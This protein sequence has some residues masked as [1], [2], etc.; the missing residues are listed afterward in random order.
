MNFHG[1]I[2]KSN[3]CLSGHCKCISIYRLKKRAAWHWFHCLIFNRLCLFSSRQLSSSHFQQCT[4]SSLGAASIS[5]CWTHKS[6][7]ISQSPS[8]LWIR[9]VD[10]ILCH[11]PLWGRHCHWL[12]I[13]WG[14][15]ECY[16]RSCANQGRLACIR[17]CSRTPYHI[18]CRTSCCKT[19]QRNWLL[20]KRNEWYAWMNWTNYQLDAFELPFHVDECE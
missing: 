4:T 13:C 9:S 5:R 14:L 12:Q 17:F 20:L 18:A 11:I 16:P 3:R 8:S 2:A 7:P 19:L 15:N 6:H 1:C 10:V